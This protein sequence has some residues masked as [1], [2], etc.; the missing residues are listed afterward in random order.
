MHLHHH[1]RAACV[2]KSANMVSANMVSILPKLSERHLHCTALHSQ[3]Q[4][5]SLKSRLEYSTGQQQRQAP[6]VVLRSR[7]AREDEPREKTR[8]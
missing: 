7:S 8:R 1:T 2:R 3:A 5:H 6:A 4:L